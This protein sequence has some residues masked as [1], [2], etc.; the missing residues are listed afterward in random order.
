MRRTKIIAT[1]GPACS[2]PARIDA[3][4]AAGM[5]VARLDLS[6]GSHDEHARA[7]E[8]VREAADRAGRPIAVLLDLAGPRI[9]VRGPPGPPLDLPAGAEFSIDGGPGAIASPGRLV[10]DHRDLADDVRAGDPI[11]LDGGRIR[12]QVI[13]VQG[14]AARCRVAEGG[15][16]REL[17]ELRLPRGQLSLPALTLQDR[18]DLAFGVERLR[19]DFV[20]LSSVRTAEDVRLARRLTSDRVPILAR[21]EK[22]QAL[23]VLDE[24]LLSSAGCLVARAQLG[25]ELP[26]NR[27]PLLQKEIIGRANLHGRLSIV[28]TQVFES[29]VER[30]APSRAELGDVANAVL[31]G[32]DAVQLSAETATGRYPVEAV[33]CLAQ[34]IEE[35]EASPRYQSQPEAALG[36]KG[37]TIT[38]AVARAA[39]A[40]SRQLGLKAIAVY[41]RSGELARMVSELRPPSP[42]IAYTAQEAV[43]RRGA[44]LWGIESRRTPTPFHETDRLVKYLT[45]DL[46]ARGIAQ[47]GDPIAIVSSTPPDRAGFGAS[48]LQI[49]VL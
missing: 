1:L 21:I 24:I 43:W 17:A 35:V 18:D 38:T 14:R 9:W 48:M 5:D 11:L 37:D 6:R 20:V 26:L 7:C 32:V 28:G 49:V 22:G 39:V 29:M 10:C 23:D 19:V 45:D 25:I 31:D 40:A 36:R 30:P 12:L 42:I 4:I 15:E 33:R 46:L 8:A 47:P 3:L 16:L 27:V 44:A 34:L 13:A 2:T 41:T